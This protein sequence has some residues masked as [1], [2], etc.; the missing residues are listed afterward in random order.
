MGIAEL[1]ADSAVLVSDPAICRK[2]SSAVADYRQMD[3]EAVELVLIRIGRR[4]WAEDGRML[5]G[6]WPLVFLLDS[7]AAKVIAQH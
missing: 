3:Q 2:A 6:E 4:Y 1:P 7:T 5:G